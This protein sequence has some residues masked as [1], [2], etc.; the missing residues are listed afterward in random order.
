[1]AS[2]I[3]IV[4]VVSRGPAGPAGGSVSPG[5]LDNQVQIKNSDTD[6]DIS[7]GFIDGADTTFTSTTGIA[8][9]TLS[10]AID[11]VNADV[12]TN[13]S[14]VAQNTSDIAQ[15]TSDIGVNTGN[16]T[17]NTNDIAQNVSDISSNT[18][19][20]S[21]NTGN[22]STNTGDIATNTSD[23]ATNASGISTNTI[24]I[25]DHESRLNVNEPAIASLEKRTELDYSESATHVD[26]IVD[27][28]M[29]K[30]T[31]GLPFSLTYGYVENVIVINGSYEIRQT[32]SGTTSG[33]EYYRTLS[34]SVWTG[35]TE[36]VLSSRIT[37]DESLI[38]SNATDIGANLTNI[39]I[40]ASNIST[41]VSDIA[42]LDIRIGTNESDISTI[43]TDVTTNT[44]DISG[45]R[46]DMTNVQSASSTNT[47]DIA[48]NTGNISTNITNISQ[49]ASDITDNDLAINIRVDDGDTATSA[50]ADD[51]A[52]LDTRVTA[53]I[54]TNTDDILII[55][56]AVGLTNSLTTNI[57]EILLNGTYSVNT[58]LPVG[59]TG[60]ATLIV[61][62]LD[63]SAEVS[64]WLTDTVE[65]VNLIRS[66]DGFVWSAWTTNT[67]SMRV[68]ANEA[69]IATNVTDIATNT[70]AITDLNDELSLDDK[71]LGTSVDAILET[72][73]FK[74]DT[75][76]PVSSTYAVLTQVST[77]ISAV[78]TGWK[79]TCDEMDDGGVYYRYHD[80][81]SWG[82]W[83]ET[84]LSQRVI[85]IEE[86]TVA[87]FNTYSTSAQS[88]AGL[89]VGNVVGVKFGASDIG[90]T[91]VNYNSTTGAITFNVA[92][93]YSLRGL[94]NFGRGTGTP[95]TPS[96]L[97]ARKLING[98]QVNQLIV[99]KIEPDNS[100]IPTS[101]NFNISVL[102]NDVFTIELIRDSSGDDSGG[103]VVANTDWGVSPSASISVYKLG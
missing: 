3:C 79:Q 29:Y 92:G 30:V 88:P 13:T 75:G 37:V 22:I 103:L 48:T 52:I 77:T 38:A 23:I 65:G 85:D 70:S 7:W 69:A 15:N 102:A 1:M 64:Q 76:L 39:N 20:I 51:L 99:V 54:Q 58:N 49:N 24:D 25:A 83:L 17:S 53:D 81:S 93:T 90:T 101:L 10:A 47:S 62:E 27:E 36:D 96:T 98:S 19:S 26:L 5:G 100:E 4:E 67:S 18:I 73:I 21:T 86:W 32:L 60:P 66:Y 97:V 59:S 80:G 12:N 44:S 78:V 33:S 87:L 82:S 9:T 56:S 89:G 74:V 11:E 94:F 35:W 55:G 43:D 50:V 2:N 68:D 46:S 72:G 61:K 16:I 71:F 8:A 57:D 95:G 14:D 63:T 42:A 31:T 41:N 40:N 45:L 34:S 6:Y 28:G 84:P 91:N